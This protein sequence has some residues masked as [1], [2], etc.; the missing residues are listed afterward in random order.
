MLEPVAQGAI[1]DH[2]M[3]GVAFWVWLVAAAAAAAVVPARTHILMAA[4]AAVW[5]FWAKGL[6]GLRVAVAGPAEEAALQQTGRPE[7]M[8]AGREGTPLAALVGL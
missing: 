1:K 2:P 5:V 7:P 3:L 8:A 6:M 4:A